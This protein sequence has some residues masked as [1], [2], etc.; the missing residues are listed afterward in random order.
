MQKKLILLSIALFFSII[1]FSQFQKGTT[2]INFNIGDIRYFS[3]R[4]KSFHKDNSLTFNPAVGRFIKNNWEAGVGMHFNS[5][6]LNDSSH[7]LY[8]QNSTTYGAFV[9]TNKYF[10]KGNLKPYLTFRMGWDHLSGK[11]IYN[12]SPLFD[13]N[14]NEFYYAIGG[15]LNWNISRRIALFTEATYLRT[16]PFN[17]NGYGRLNL[18]AG[19][20]IFFNN[21]KHR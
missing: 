10:G 20:R 2:S 7:G 14:R 12:N 21:K 17:R 1:S 13:F 3:I 15:G 6:H 9:Y 19:I 4:N 18:T 8:Y 5:I 16:S 11:Y